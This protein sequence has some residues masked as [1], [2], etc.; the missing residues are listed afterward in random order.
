MPALGRPVL[1]TAFLAGLLPQTALGWGWGVHRLVNRAATTHLPPDFAGFA[2]WADSLTVLATAADER[3]CCVP[4][5]SIK[6]YIDIDDYD[7]FFSGTLPHSYDAMVARYG[8]ERVLSNGTVPWVVDSTIVVLAAHFRDRD[9][10]RAVLAAAD[11]GHYVADSHEP[12][13]LT[14]NYDGQLTGQRGTHARHESQMTNLHL[15][16]LVP[17]PL[18][19][20]AYV[21]PLDTVFDWIE[22]IYPGV[23]LILAADQEARA[24]ADGNTEAEVYFDVLWLRTGDA[25]RGWIRDAS[26]AVAGTWLTAWRSAGAP[27]LPG[28]PP[29]RA[30]GPSGPRLAPN[31]PNPFNPSTLV[32]FELAAPA[33]VRLRVLDARGRLVRVLLDGPALGGE[34]CLPW[35]GKDEAGRPAPSGAYRLRLEQGEAAVERTAVLVR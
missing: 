21:R 35:D 31:Y 26:L 7:E 15:H 3:K 16:E 11:L 24:A 5:E 6:H 10:R 20:A 17:P 18:R 30:P 22:E 14:T 23:N 33:A 12:L 25:T 28:D 13:H 9:W 27:S 34:Q 32:R 19:A 1:I 2:R 29:A 4:G 8:L